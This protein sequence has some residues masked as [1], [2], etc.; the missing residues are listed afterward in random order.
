MEDGAASPCL[1]APRFQDSI[2][3]D[4]ANA[5]VL[6]GLRVETSGRPKRGGRNPFAF[7]LD[8]SLL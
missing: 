1:Q 5:P 7:L 8:F 6:V 4:A 2:T 3:D